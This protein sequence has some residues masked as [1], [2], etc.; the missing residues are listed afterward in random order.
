MEQPLSVLFTPRKRRMKQDLI[1]AR[2]LMLKQR[3]KIK[4]LNQKVRRLQDRNKSLKD[5]LKTL[6]E[7]NYVDSDLFNKLNEDIT[8]ANIFNNYNKKK[9]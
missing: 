8:A 2:T 7:E 4:V 3:N 6:K 5:I 9:N 1:K